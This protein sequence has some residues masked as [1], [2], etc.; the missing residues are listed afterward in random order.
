MQIEYWNN[1][2]WT[3]QV[4]NPISTGGYKGCSHVQNASKTNVKFAQVCLKRLFSDIKITPQNTA[5]YR[6]Y[7]G[8]ALVYATEHAYPDRTDGAFQQKS[9]QSQLSCST[10]HTKTYFLACFTNPL[11]MWGL[12]WLCVFINR[13]I[14]EFLFSWKKIRNEEG[15]Y[16]F[17]RAGRG[18]TCCIY[19][20]FWVLAHGTVL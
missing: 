1:R 7:A 8:T 3:S 19:Q 17:W 20:R 12:W 9:S 16:I 11:H 2:F 15:V 6:V 10:N 18:K 4:Y 14:S 13:E 5:I